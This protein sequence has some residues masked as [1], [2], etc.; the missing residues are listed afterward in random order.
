ML[1]LSLAFAKIETIE[2][3]LDVLSRHRFG[4][5]DQGQQPADDATA[6]AELGS[7]REST[8]GTRL[9]SGMVTIL[10]SKARA[11]DL[12][13]KQIESGRGLGDRLARQVNSEAAYTG[14]MHD[15]ERW[16]RLSLDVVGV[17][18]GE[19]SKEHKELG[20]SD[21]ILIAAMGTPWHMEA[22]GALERHASSLN[23]LQSLVERLGLA[24]E[25]R[26][27]GYPPAPL[28]EANVK[29]TEGQSHGE[30]HV[31]RVF[32]VH[33]RD[34]ATREATARTLERSGY[35]TVILHEEANKGRTLIEKFEQHAAEAGYAVIL[36]TADDVGG[37]S[38]TE[39]QPR[40]RQ[41]V[42]FEMGFF[43]G[44]LGRDRVA[45]LYDSSV[46]K[47]SDIQGIVYIEL[48]PAGAWKTE[49][50]RELSS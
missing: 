39:L 30:K 40:A 44:L 32:I 22:R 42:V 47:P 8:T 3:Y 12:L 15:R 17:I 6:V 49:L 43:Y 48:D 10:V 33:G 2:D 27:D 45:V 4:P 5:P 11:E 21:R 36:L 37:P 7:D 24:E 14:W 29:Q 1:V 31:D 26:P 35:K 16:K 41:N 28:S 50:V 20:S 23:V 25:T 18:Y 19:D 13:G 9:P 34:E 46:E 38:P